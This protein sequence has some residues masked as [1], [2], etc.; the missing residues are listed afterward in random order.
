MKIV[1]LFY[2]LETTG[3]DPRKHS[4][5]QIAGIIEVNDEIVEEFDIKTRPHPKAIIE[6]EALSVC[7]IT[8]EQ[9][10]AYP[11][12]AQAYRSFTRKMNEY[13]NK[14]DKKEGIF[15]VGFN[16]IYF[17]DTFLRAWFEQNGDMYFGAYFWKASL[18]VSSLA[19]EYLLLRRSSMPSFKLK[20]VAL[21]LGIDVDPAKLH[22][23]VYDCK[24]MRKV[25]RI[26]TRREIEL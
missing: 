12:M 23:G 13:I 20:R 5:H 10:L 3:T 15:L 19:A 1:K 24:I 14:Y 21:E 11:P 4:I 8:K 17:D 22:D 16:N 9:I 2:D 7:G 18:D 6:P 26:V 25:Y